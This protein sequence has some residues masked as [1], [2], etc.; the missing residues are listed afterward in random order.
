[1]TAIIYRAKHPLIAQDADPLITEVLVPPCLEEALQ[2]YIASRCFVS[3]GNQ[4][5]AA[6]AS[7]YMGIY[8]EQVQR[9]ERDNLLQSSVGD[10]NIK[11][12]LKGFI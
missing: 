7:Y 8:N 3:L 11:L 4:A 12:Y 1:M 10:T 6:L 2:A 5:S 9:V